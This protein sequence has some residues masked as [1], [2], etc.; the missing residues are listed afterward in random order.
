M[1]DL[2][3]QESPDKR[4]INCLWLYVCVL[5]PVKIKEPP[6]PLHLLLTDSFLSPLVFI[7]LTLSC[8]ISALSIPLLAQPSNMELDKNSCQAQYANLSIHPCLSVI[9]V[10]SV[11]SLT[12]I[13]T[14]SLITNSSTCLGMQGEE[15]KTWEQ[16]ST[17]RLEMNICKSP[18]TWKK[19]ACFMWKDDRQTDICLHTVSFDIFRITEWAQLARGCDVFWWELKLTALPWLPVVQPFIKSMPPLNTTLPRGAGPCYS[20]LPFP[21]WGR[22]HRQTDE[23]E[24][25]ACLLLWSDNSTVS[26]KKK[27]N[28]KKPPSNSFMKQEPLHLNFTFFSQLYFLLSTKNLPLSVKIIV[29]GLIACQWV[30]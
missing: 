14:V 2:D 18:I 17:R 23:L 6:L 5:Q 25:P 12:F 4:L 30:T 13:S 29:I 24:P 10:I 19:S 11:A 9:C 1:R 8:F 20:L 26:D 7:S 3:E 27:K 28:K 22:K 21:V 15:K 16:L